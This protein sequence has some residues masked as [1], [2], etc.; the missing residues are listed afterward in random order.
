MCPNYFKEQRHVMCSPA[1]EQLVPQAWSGFGILPGGARQPDPLHAKSQA[2]L[3]AE[4]TALLSEAG[5]T[6]LS[7][8]PS[9]LR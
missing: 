8:V 5:I 4:G 3:M 7:R 2:L 1:C 6:V 9:V